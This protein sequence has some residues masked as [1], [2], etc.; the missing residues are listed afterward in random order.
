MLQQAIASMASVKAIGE[1]QAKED[2][3]KLVLEILGIAFAFLPFLDDLT[4]ELELLDGAFET[5]APKPATSPWA[6]RALSS[7][8]PPTPPP[9]PWC[10][11]VSLGRGACATRT[12]SRP[13]PPRVAP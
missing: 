4:H 1:K 12:T 7:T 9:P 6:S 11:W 8:P 5:V 13:R 3:I 2:K 10:S